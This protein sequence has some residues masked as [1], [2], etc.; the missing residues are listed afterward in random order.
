[1]KL[2]GITAV[3]VLLA[4][5]ASGH[6]R[7]QGAAP[8][9]SEAQRLLQ[10]ASDPGDFTDT[11]AAGLISLKHKPSGLVCPFGPDPQG[12]SLRA[13]P[14][15]V[16]CQMASASEIDTLEAFHTT[17]ASDGDLQDAVGRALGQFNGAQPVSGFTDSK[18][19]RPNAPPHVSQRYVAATA[20]GERLFVRVAYAQVGGWFVL[21]R[22]V[23]TAAGAQSADFDGERR[24]LLAIGQMM[25]RQAQGAGR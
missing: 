1:M 20:N 9:T 18:S 8:A 13:S 14:E 5:A 17:P 25:D 7:A 4:A 23:S 19:D 3:V 10:G 2:A 16:I 15:G 21:Q 6:A 22:V 12:N 24:I 11:S